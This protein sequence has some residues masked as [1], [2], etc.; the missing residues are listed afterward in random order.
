MEWS[1][2]CLHETFKRQVGNYFRMRIL[3]EV[4][5]NYFC[6]DVHTP[7]PRLGRAAAPDPLKKLIGL[8]GE[9]RPG[10]IL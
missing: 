7:A 5:R 3:Y 8:D 9:W 4:A 2:G 6:K 1:G 10:T